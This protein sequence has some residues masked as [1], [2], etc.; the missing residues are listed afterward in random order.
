MR[1]FVLVSERGSPM[2]SDGVRKMIART[3]KK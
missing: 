3:A 2:S 1:G